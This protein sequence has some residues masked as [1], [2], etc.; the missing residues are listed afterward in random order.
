LASLQPKKYSGVV[1]YAVYFLRKNISTSLSSIGVWI[2][3]LKKEKTSEDFRG[4]VSARDQFSEGGGVSS[5]SG[6]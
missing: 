6:G 1:D 2:R 5:F 4:V 3:S